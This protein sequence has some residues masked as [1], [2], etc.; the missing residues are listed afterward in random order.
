MTADELKRARHDLGLTCERFAEVF[1]VA[2]GRTVRGWE[3]GER[4]GQPAPVP[5]PIE[6]LVLIALKFPAVRKWLGIDD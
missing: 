4:N 3:T 5:K 6:L 2:S 1:G